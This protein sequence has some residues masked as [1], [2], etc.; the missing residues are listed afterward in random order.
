MK[1]LP[2]CFE[3]VRECEFLAQLVIESEMPWLRDLEKKLGVITLAGAIQASIEMM[4][5]SWMVEDVD[6]ED[7]QHCPKCG[8][9]REPTTD[10]GC[11]GCSTA[12]VDF[13]QWG[14]E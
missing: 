13:S 6:D 5:D 2:V 9:C 10:G 11:T 14:R 4:L 8:D 3:H 12:P 7:V 1:Y